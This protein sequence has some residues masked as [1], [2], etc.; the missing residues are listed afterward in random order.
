MR[1]VVIPPTITT[2]VVFPIIKVLQY[3]QV[4]EDVY[5]G[6]LRPANLPLATAELII[7]VTIVEVDIGLNKMATVYL[8]IVDFIMLM[9]MVGVEL[10]LN[11]TPTLPL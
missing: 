11:R 4:T 3:T 10:G 1:I 5:T 7:L 9:L 8:T 2:T 6:L